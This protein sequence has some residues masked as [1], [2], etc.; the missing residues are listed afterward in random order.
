MSLIENPEAKNLANHVNFGL[1]NIVFKNPVFLNFGLVHI[2]V[3]FDEE[4]K[5]RII[6]LKKWTPKGVK[7]RFFVENPFKNGLFHV[8]STFGT[9]LP[10]KS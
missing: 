10:T 7:Q 9:V 3:K 4:F 1:L 8:F 5:N 6:F 2:D